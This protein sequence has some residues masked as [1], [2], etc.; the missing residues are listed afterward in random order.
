MCEDSNDHQLESEDSRDQQLEIQINADRTVASVL[1]P[2]DFDPTL[3]NLALVEQYVS[4]SG[5]MINPQ[6]Y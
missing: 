5:V 4:D 2:A 3:L 6:W 1:I